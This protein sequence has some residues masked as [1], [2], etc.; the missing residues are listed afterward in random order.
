[1]WH[2]CKRNVALADLE[3]VDGNVCLQLYK[4]A[5]RRAYAAAV[6]TQPDILYDRWRTRE[7]Y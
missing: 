7:L 5:D 4:S 3:L 6:T 1:M 2:C